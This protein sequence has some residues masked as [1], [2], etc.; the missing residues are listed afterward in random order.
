MDIE[1]RQY[2]RVPTDESI[3]II[4]ADGSVLPAV[5]LDISLLGMQLLCDSLTARRVTRN[6]DA[7][8]SIQVRFPVTTADG[9][10]SV[11]A[12]CRVVYLRHF[13]EDEC[14]LGLQYK[15]FVGASYNWLES[16]VDQRVSYPDE[17]LLAKH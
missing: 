4:D 13:P 5:A 14:R 9:I 6:L 2:P 12:W 8:D 16:F 3:Q 17:R 11:N 15:S 7:A 10:G 1:R